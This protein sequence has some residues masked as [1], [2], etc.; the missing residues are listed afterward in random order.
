MLRVEHPLIRAYRELL[1]VGEGASS[2]DIKTAYRGLAHV[3]HPDKNIDK[4]TTAT[5]VK[6]Q[7]AYGILSDPLSIEK[8]NLEYLDERCLE[9]C[10]EGLDLNFGSFF[11]HR[12]Y[13]DN[14]LPKIPPSRRIA[15]GSAEAMLNEPYLADQ[16]YSKLE[17]DR[18]ILD[19]PSLDYAELV[20]AGRMS[21]ADTQSLRDAY[22]QKDFSVLPWYIA[23]NEG[24][25]HFLNR[26]YD[27]S[28]RIYRQLIRRIPNN[29][30]FLYRLGICCEI[31]AFSHTRVVMGRKLIN[32]R[33]ARHAVKCFHKAIDVGETR[34]VLPQRC[35]T[36]RKTLADFYEAL[37]RKR[38]ALKAWEEIHDM[39]PRQK[40][41]RKRVEDGENII[42]AL[43]K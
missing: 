2:D 34:P 6:I 4:D 7:E 29:I 5:F 42:H 11:G 28:L 16:A 26:D 19:D 23:N 27:T 20:L 40:E 24:I 10:I 36:I 21:D 18:S 30:I 9:K 41:A 38:K 3:Y 1:R 32:R 39:A 35:M 31:A 17:G 13:T 33:L 22:M 37:G 43:L 12:F 8:L 25:I 14:N 15:L